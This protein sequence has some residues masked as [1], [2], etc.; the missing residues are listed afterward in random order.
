MKKVL[1][2]LTLILSITALFGCKSK[3]DFNEYISQLR[4]DVL[5]AENDLCSISCYLETR[6]SPF[7]SDG[8]VN[9]KENLVILKLSPKND[10]LKDFGVSFTTD[11]TYTENFSFE[12]RFNCYVATVSVETMPSKNL[13]ITLSDENGNSDITLTSKKQ[14]STIA[15]DKAL[16]FV[17]S[18][19]KEKIDDLISSDDNFEI[20][21]RLISEEQDF[22]FVGI[23]T[24][25]N[26]F[27]FLVDGKSGKIIAQK[28]INNI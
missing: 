17:Y 25:E 3:K 18:Q 21:L 15:Y 14:S 2:F 19:N 12:P 9:A 28:N 10:E 24:S 4:Y 1:L 8:I 5:F 7:V 6:E 20:N 13:K 11:K 27:C 16:S 23:T 26:S 22:W